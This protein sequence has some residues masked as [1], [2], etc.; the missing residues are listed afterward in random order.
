MFGINIIKQIRLTTIIFLLSITSLG[1]Q[2]WCPPGATWQFDFFQ[3]S[4]EGYVEVKYVGDSVV[5]GKTCKV[6]RKTE[7]YYDWVPQKYGSWII[8]R[9]YTYLDSN[10]VYIWRLGKFWKLYDFGALVGESWIIPGPYGGSQFCD[11]TGSVGVDS[12][13]TITIDTFNLNYLRIS[14]NDTN[15]Q[16]VRLGGTLV[17]RIGCITGYMFPE[18]YCIPHDGEEAGNFRCYTDSLF[19]LYQVSSN[20]CDF[21]IG[22]DQSILKQSAVQLYPNPTS[23]FI[24]IEIDAP[25]IGSYE[26]KLYSLLGQEVMNIK[27]EQLKIKIDISVL[28]QGIYFLKIENEQNIISK[29]KIIK[30][31]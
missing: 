29:R 13:S 16:G 23:D 17:E 2:V 1:A 9:E 31:K 21:I 27:L 4:A 15:M 20:P 10:I 22:I 8:G 5:G 18:R 12:I 11:S 28:D 3:F 7:Y 6:L 19:G 24:T 26:L 14:P 25:L 30:L